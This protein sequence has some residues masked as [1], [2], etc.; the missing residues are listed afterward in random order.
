MS[1]DVKQESFRTPKL[2]VSQLCDLTQSLF[3][4][5]FKF[6]IDITKN[7]QFVNYLW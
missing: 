1:V 6:S 7:Y 4:T 5:V 3:E 2:V